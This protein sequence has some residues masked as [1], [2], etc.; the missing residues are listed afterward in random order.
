VG[1]FIER[2]RH[3]TVF[4]FRRR[5]PSDLRERIGRSH[6]YVTLRT[7]ERREAIVRARAV[8]AYTDIR[9]KEMRHMNDQSNYAQIN[10]ELHIDVDELTGKRKKVS[11]TDVK[12]HE[13]EAVEALA[14][15]LTESGDRPAKTDTPTI[16]QAIEEALASGDL[17]PRTRKEYA[18]HWECLAAHFGEHTPLSGVTQDAF[19]KYADAIRAR[20]DWADKSKNL[21]IVAGATLFNRLA[22]R[23]SSV[24]T[25]QTKALKA[26][27]S[28]P[29]SQDRDAFDL[30]ELE[31]IFANARRYLDSQPAKFWITV[32]PAFLGCR[33]EE[34]A[35]AHLMADF[36]ED[37]DAG[38]YVLK[39]SEDAEEGT[40]TKSVKTFAGWRRIPI[41]PVLV[42]AGFIAYLQ[43]EHAAGSATPFGRQW[44]AYTD[45]STGGTI[46]SHSAVKWGGRELAKLRADG[47]VSD[48]KQ[49]YFHSLRHTFVTLLA[50]AGV[51]EEWRAGL[52]GQA[53]GGINS[54]VYSKAREDVSV[55]GPMLVD[56][57]KPLEAVFL[58]AVV[59]HLLAS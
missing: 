27:R 34:L 24:P 17:K 58:E 14:K 26:K 36:P 13:R 8:A 9:F 54:Q 10:F 31:A 32:A 48:G 43:G 53:Y 35:Q 22:P 50:S 16:R 59:G 49:T 45:P 25:I 33:V 21:T 30:S 55:T 28:R 47:L 19:A 39:I 20:T 7:Q 3:G 52:A 38:F 37:T 6:V 23:N 2:S 12:A 1:S 46:H 15:S 11:F 5:V 56:A 18:R 57:L 42:D 51:T 40:H 29:A 4:Y 44:A 41:H